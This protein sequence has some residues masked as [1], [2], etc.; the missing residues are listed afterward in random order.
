[1]WYL[2]WQGKALL[3]DCRSL[4]TTPVQISQGSTKIVVN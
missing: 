2:E 4:N 3:I 1:M